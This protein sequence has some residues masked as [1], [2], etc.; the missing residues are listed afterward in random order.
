MDTT[1]K[2]TLIV[3]TCEMTAYWYELVEIFSTE[4]H[5][6]YNWKMSRY[7]N[8]IWPVIF[9]ILSIAIA[10]C[11]QG[12]KTKDSSKMTSIQLWCGLAAKKY[13][14]YGWY[15]IGMVDTN[16]CRCIALGTPQGIHTCTMS[17]LPFCTLP[18]MAITTSV[19]RQAVLGRTPASMQFVSG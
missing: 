12:E 7:N 10:S 9:V 2:T 6:T 17:R 15:W 18:K 3:L 14:E 11:Q 19:W 13:E 1:L 16:P 5:I 8:S 4:S